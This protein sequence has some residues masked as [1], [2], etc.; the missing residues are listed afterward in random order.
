MKKNYPNLPKY[1]IVCF[2][3]SIL[4]FF[5]MEMS[6][7]SFNSSN[8]T[9]E[10]LVN[11]TSLAF[12]PDDKL[13]VAQQDGT[14]HQYTVSRDAAPP[15]SGTY[16]VT[17]NLVINDIK[18]K[19]KNHNDSGVLDNI[20]PAVNQK[21][22]VTGLVVAGTTSNP[23]I[24]VSSSD[25]RIGGASSS[26][27]TGELDRNLD[28][29]SG[30]LSRL[31]WNGS[32]WNHV[33]L[34][35]GL[36]RCEENHATN[37]MDIFTKD[38]ST[39]LLL[40]QGG[41]TNKGA[42]S[43][44]FGG[45]GETY[46]A[47]AILIVNL[48]QLEGMTVYTDPRT[49]SDYVY[50]LP[51]LNDPTR[52]DIDNTDPEF[53]YPSGHPMY[54]ATIDLGD[55]FGG[56]N[57]R[58]Q[59]IPEPGGPVQIFSTGWRNGYDVVVTETNL[60]YS[61]DNGGNST[62][63]G[64]PV[65]RL[66][67][68][69][70]KGDESTTTYD[71]G[72]GD[73]VT[74]EFNESGSATVWDGLHYIGTI[75]DPNG[76]YYAGHPVPIR[77]FPGQA[78][79]ISYTYNGSSWVE[80]SRHDFSALLS[81][82][83][84]YFN[85]SFTM[86]N[87]PDD[88]DQGEFLSADQNSGKVNIFD[89]VTSSTN[90]I[91]EY[92]AGNFNDA[93]KGDLLTASFNGN[94]N[95]Y[96]LNASGTGILAKDNGFLSGFGSVPL[97]VIAQGDLDV[98]PG[99]IWAATYGSGNIT[100]FE[101]D[102][103]GSCPQPGEQGYD[104]LA[105]S[106]GDGYTNGDEVDNGTNHCSGGSKPEDNDGD[107]VSNLNDADD[108]NDGI[109][110]VN[111]PFQWD[112]DNG[113]TTNLPIEYPFWNNDPG[114]GFAGLGF[115]GWMTNGS[116][117]YLDQY[118]FDNL[119]FGGAG[120]KATIDF[121]SEGNALGTS[122]NQDNG[123]Q[124]GVNVDSNSNPFTV[125]AV[126]ETPFGGND[127][128][129]T[130][131]YG[132]QIGLGDQ[133]N[134]FKLAISTGTSTS[135]NEYGFDTVLEN[136]GTVTSNSYDAAG[137]SAANNIHL[138][139]SVNPSANTAQPFYSF[140]GGSTVL[141][142]GSTISLPTSFLNAGDNQG[143]AVGIISTS[144][145]SG[146]EYTAT[147][148]YIN[149]TEDS[150]GELALTP[151][152][153]DFGTLPVTSGPVELNTFAQNIGGPSSGTISITDV[154]FTGTDS[155]LFTNGSSLPLTVG[156]GTS[157]AVPITF[158]PDGNAGAKSANVVITHS[159]TNSPLTVP[160]TTNLSDNT[161]ISRVNA[162]GA[163]VSSTDGGVDWEDNSAGGATSGATYSVN[164]GNVFS[165]GGAFQYNN[166]DASIPAY[167]DQTTFDAIFAQERNDEATGSEMEFTFPVTNGNYIV[168]LF[169]GNSFSGTSQIGQRVF[170][171]EIEGT[172]V[173]NNLDLIE[174]FGHQVAG[175]LSFS[176]P[177][178][179]GVLNL[180]FLHEVENPLVNAIEILDAA[181][182]LPFDIVPIA[183]Q[184]NYAGQQANLT[185]V[186]FGGDEG[187]PIIYSISGQPD[188]VNI[189]TSSGLISGT[190]TENA[191]IGGPNNDGIHQVT[192]TA[193]RAGS[194]N[195]QTQFTWTITSM[196]TFRINAGGVQ[197]NATDSESDWLE[198][199]TGGIY[200]GPGYSVNTGGI[201]NSNLDYA[202]RHSSIPS[203]IDQATFDALF[204]QERFDTN[205]GSDMDFAIPMLNG[206]Y[207][208][209]LYM[210]NAFSGTSQPGERV[211]DILLE[212]G[213]V[214]QNFD[215]IVEFGH[216]SGGMLSFPVSVTD[217]VLNIGFS[218]TV[219][220]ALVNAIEIIADNSQFPPI[221]IDPI[222]DQ[223]HQVGE[224]P[225]L[226]ITASGGDPQGNFEFSLSGQP[227]G[228]DIEP[229]NGLVFG[230]IQSSAV[231]G[232][233][234]GD[235]VHN[236]TVLVNKP[237]SA[238]ATANFTWTIGQDWVEKNEDENYTARH[239]CSFVQAGD[240]FY[241]MGGRENATAIDVY[242]YTTDS[243]VELAN[244]TPVVN[245]TQLEFNHFQATEYEGLI[246]VIGAFKTNVFPNEVPADYIWA[247]DPTTNEW[248]QG[249]E[250]PSGRKRGSTGLVI[251]NDKFY[252][253]GG[254]T[255]GHDGGY[256]AWFDEYDP[257]TGIWTPLADAPRARDHFHAAV[258]G[259]KMYAVGGRLSGGPGGV[260][261]P[262]I[263]EV[264]VYD[265]TNGTWS[266]LPTGQNL[267][268]E[269]AAPAV[270]NFE[271]KL[272][273][274][275]GEGNGQAYDT[276]EQYNP[277]T[278]SWSTLADMNHARHGTQAIVSGNGIYILG[279]SPN[280]GGGNQKNMEYLGADNATGVPSIS[281][282]LSAPSIVDIPDGGS[283][284]ILISTEDG[285]VGIMVTSME[286]TGA[287]AADFSITS[288]ELSPGLIGTSETHTVTVALSG[289]GAGRNAVL[290]INYG[291]SSTTIDLTNNNIPPVVENP[292]TQNNV[293]G[294]SVSLQIVATDASTNLDYS[295]T[296][297]PPD[298]SIDPNTG[299]ITG[300]IA[301]AQS[302]DG[303][304]QEENG[305]IIIETESGT[306]DPTWSLTT[307]DNETGI[308]GGSNYFSGTTAGNGGTIPYQ[309]NI[310]TPGVY[311]F[312]WK[313]FYSG[314]NS[315]EENDSWLRFP[316]N[317]DVWFFGFRGN[318]VSE[319]NL[320][321]KIQNDFTNVVF[322]GGTSRYFS[323][324][325]TESDPSDDTAPVGQT[326]NGY[327][328][329]FLSGAQS[330]VYEWESFTS[331]NGTAHEIY[332]WFVNPGTYTMEISERSSG[333]AIHKVALYLVDGPNYTD[334]QLDAFPES[335]TGGGSQGA[336]ANSPYTVDVTVTDDG[337]PQESTTEQF[338]WN[339]GPAGTTPPTALAE[340][341]PLTGV[342]PLQVTF[343]GSNSTDD[344]SIVSYFW[345]FKNGNTSTEA[346]PPVE[347]F[348]SPGIYEV[349]LTVTDDDGLTDT[350][351]VTIQVD[352]ANNPPTA[353]AEASPESGAA[354]LQV[355]FTGSN[356]TDDIGVVSYAWD[357]KDGGSST[358]ADPIYTFDSG[359]TY[360]VELTVTDGGG[361]T[362]TDTVTITVNESPVALAE[363]TP[364][365]GDAPLQVTF[366]GSNSTDSDGTIESYAWDFGDGGTST[367]ADPVYTFN[368]AGTYD[369]ELTVTDD[370]GLTDT[371]TVTITVNEPNQQPTALAEATPLEGDAPL[372]VTFT[373]SNST[374]SDGTVESYAW[375][376]GDGGTSTEADP[377]Y[378]FNTVG[379]YDVELT[380][381][382]DGG[383]TNTD[384]VTITVNE[385]NQQPTALA[386]ATPLEGDAP[387]QVTFTGSNSTDSDGTI[388]SYAWDFGD[389]GTSTEADPVYTFN[390]AG[391][392]NV[393]LTVTD[394]GGLTD[395]DT[396]T[397]VVSDPANE[398]PVAVATA[399]PTEGDA[400]LPVIFDG[401]GSTDDVGI[402]S[403]FWDF[404]DGTTSNEI[405]PVTTFDIAGTYE[406]ELT[407]TDG[408]GLMNTTT[409]TITVNE[410]AGNE[411]PEAVASA[412]P[413][414][415]N[416]PLEVMFTGSNSTD[417]VG[418]VSYAWDFGD[419]G[420]SAEADPV[421]TFNTAG[422]YEVE[423]TV[424]DGG[425]LTD[426]DT[427]T[428]QVTEPGGN[429]AP[430]AVVSATPLSGQAPLEVSFIGSSSTDDVAVVSYLW[431]FGDGETSTEPDPTHTFE[432]AGS[433]EVVLTVEDAEGLTDTATVTI[434]VE[435]NNPSGITDFEAIIAPNPA[436]ETAYLSILNM[437][438]GRTATMIYLHDSTGR[439][440]GAFEPQEVFR[441]NRYEIP[442][443]LLR[444]ELYYIK[445]ELNNGDPIVVPLL[446]K[447][448]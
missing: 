18:L 246:W 134:Y 263:A 373:G 195:V 404:K 154:S 365:E 57:T 378:T 42:P 295:A 248:I 148:D 86:A 128:V 198:N 95:R 424:T 122:N 338:I 261:A 230:T 40:Q 239:E 174:E 235:G 168:N 308:I 398:P 292:G 161:S 100:V 309:I 432:F 182:Q 273:V 222:A 233:P 374:D 281:S 444:D 289:T 422:T 177:I 282:T 253:V 320:I 415:G 272:V 322:P 175:M 326:G 117:D 11:P 116:T 153:V 225:D 65:I 323:N 305:L 368:T 99:T 268:S 169:L 203:Y 89:V 58:N 67:D 312:D 32:G 349:E 83:S 339:I 370:G 213:V 87:F 355:T 199:A 249:P 149:V 329:I 25:P 216:Q 277:A 419:G 68:G 426:T 27:P 62:W 364:L 351:T 402:V 157:I 167:I 217:G 12:G 228:I 15:G 170:D 197:V 183:D 311:R 141:P 356:S 340:A 269:R 231:S 59:A 44:N 63:G 214:R 343:T 16:S 127:P 221:I 315:T 406:V 336:A 207:A 387:L 190:I 290:A 417:D 244:S 390:T 126:I 270:V 306:L 151:D 72:A 118:D 262:T 319:A 366:T 242:D 442:V 196:T 41:N 96:E 294:E 201:F 357:F 259:D 137:F 328:K 123:F 250:I 345:D 384:S 94:I 427:V 13:Y 211:Y 403:Y 31:T 208:V 212:G 280:L 245:S 90:G 377:V 411:V 105:D 189:N 397:I 310:T 388:E 155:N 275:G 441:D 279:G 372:Q 114:T 152:P 369:V 204:A 218:N 416:A 210:G 267:P 17:G 206:N 271:D 353:V 408:G 224:N 287:D 64:L 176:A 330:E 71:P 407:V 303:V 80:A 313:S 304:F 346:D 51:T 232:G 386:E 429:Q 358:E 104:P 254:N 124:F 37:G 185:A 332:V 180:R 371:D 164:T 435:E 348:D 286:I 38:G 145:G 3:I 445:I 240:K 56:N 342:A 14:I 318:P 447:N 88:P 448:Q 61:V 375:D 396:V 121:V 24:Y 9:G 256:V 291:T 46:L 285:N 347:T 209:N 26:N 283:R 325:G 4:G 436:D 178:T 125:Y 302:G 147:W 401:S 205:G 255:D 192:V 410:P 299:L 172:I 324:P 43:N 2:V 296:G 383:L 220:S 29:N 400:P 428:I 110:D 69:T 193:S 60:V 251:Y 160:I 10:S 85:S 142:L 107:F 394:D 77:A 52:T 133:D 446:V 35:R 354:P 431:D 186:A 102:D 433:F 8:L 352:G 381:T 238:P 74:N 423:L 405:N 111:D 202:N 362:D 418:I 412:T 391:T 382:D 36:P 53:P 112:A 363:A 301:Q 317:N 19:V 276:T 409:I 78:E 327:F 420:T 97:D 135:D 395:T 179:D 350:D 50:D 39:Y 215:L 440:L 321:D 385:P 367:E 260:F 20:D 392:Y 21:R 22:Q 45:I 361:L 188:G 66:N 158:A 28:T 414:S 82:V 258:I 337:N 314:S 166:R 108:D 119:S 293:E 421:Y 237:G 241:L 5:Q 284:D 146:P 73:Y 132:I 389:G 334:A 115:T 79:V 200:N 360:E 171:I 136:G 307:L 223:N 113:T 288:G 165:T 84:G 7:Q 379:T 76:T 335:N 34:V 194:S 23:I 55:P 159:G 1:F 399:N 297:L 163:Q 247:F 243:W 181:G 227:A 257:R 91:C 92:T 434:E 143:L 81:G 49:G 144:V 173:R 234:N 300:T 430:E 252:I 298:L 278:Q 438:E 140:D 54:N 93:M 162:G 376:F 229:T 439:L 187:Q 413:D 219:Q 6:A 75:N 443:Y 425:G 359:G 266:T 274:I 101:P 70:F 30:V 48:T 191:L 331:D 98:F 109:A 344:S 139:I 120:G 156:P 437:P 393:E 150:N 184:A 103:F 264:D 265:F 226:T 380:V 316:N 47:G 106:D 333:H 236:V 138:Y 130:E 33:D 131:S 129:D 341:T